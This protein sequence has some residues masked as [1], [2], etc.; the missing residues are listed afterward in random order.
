MNE[1]L[2]NFDYVDKTAFPLK[3]KCWTCQATVYVTGNS[4]KRL[5]KF[6]QVHCL[7]CKQEGKDEN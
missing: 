7:D 4:D 3:M 5:N 1:Y 2:Q 6:K